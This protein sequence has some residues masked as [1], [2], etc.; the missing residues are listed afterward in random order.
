MAEVIAHLRDD[1]K[2]HCGLKKLK[3]AHPNGGQL[4]TSSRCNVIFPDRNVIAVQNIQ[5]FVIV[6]PYLPFLKGFFRSHRVN[7]AL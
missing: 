4:Q 7:L 6:R 1:E 3:R 2:H 5:T